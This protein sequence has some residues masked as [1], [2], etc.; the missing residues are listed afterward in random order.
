MGSSFGRVSMPAYRILYIPFI[1]PLNISQSPLNR[2]DW[3]KLNSEAK[4]DV[5]SRSY[6]RESVVTS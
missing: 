2:S 5:L 6:E 4:G 1:Y 3:P